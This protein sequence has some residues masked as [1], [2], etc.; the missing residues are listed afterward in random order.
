MYFIGGLVWNWGRQTY[1]KCP[2][3]DVRKILCEDW[4]WIELISDSCEMAR[5]DIRFVDSSCSVAVWL[6][7]IVVH[8][9][10]YLSYDQCVHIL[11]DLS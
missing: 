7:K 10:I 2:L 4:R 9:C 5:F 8:L 3:V 6:V 1:S 11:S